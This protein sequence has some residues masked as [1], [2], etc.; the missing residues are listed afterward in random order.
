MTEG[1][2]NTLLE[3]FEQEVWSKVPHLEEKDGEA[4]VVNA[5]PLVDITE[6]F[7]ECAKKVYKINLDDANLKVFGKF[8]S[9]LLTGSIKVRPAAN[10]IHDA[11][12]TGKLTSGQTVIEATSGNFGIALGLLSK[13]ELNVIAL[14]S[15]KLQEGVFEELRN[16]NIR[17]MDLDMDICP[18]PGMEG[19]QDLLVAKASAANI[20]SQ[21][22]NLGFDTDIFDKAGS[23]I[24]S[25]LASQDIINL[26][27]FLA[28]IYGFFC[29]EQYDSQLNID[30]HRTIT[31][32]EID[33]QL[34]E[35]GDSLEGYNIFCTF[36]TGGT[37]G[38]LSRYISEKYGKKSV[39]VIYPPTNQ[40]VAGIRTKANADGLT[41]YEPEIYAAEQEMDWEQAKLLLK[42]FVEKGH[43]IGE[44]SALEL[45]AALQKA[46]SEG[47]GKFVVM[48]CDGI[49]KYKKNLASIGQEGPMQVSLQEANAGNYDKV[50]WIHA[51]YTP[52][53]QGIELIA[54]SL[55]ID[56]S[57]ISVP[58]A[59]TAQELLTT[60]Q[61]PE[62]LSKDLEGD[63]K[64][65]LVCMAGKTSLMA[66]KVLATKGV[67]TD[68]L[69]GGITELPEGKTKQLSDLIRQA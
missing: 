33:Q 42:F 50:I 58:D 38:G 48:I 61:I 65:L 52:L 13:L 8:D 21:L 53:E 45:Y 22:S 62:A 18:A 60:R 57:K 29:P 43:D 3:R 46:S 27:K 35:K 10:I 4:K 20:R 44:S 7:K 26:A 25:L 34:H 19:K 24:E 47:G 68:S 9:A 23:E 16:V 36:G 40:D 12:V 66:A 56:K 11:I 64:P 1:I 30:A 51:Q 2:D 17:T 39:Y 49:E 55:G 14:V 28:K 63:G 67:I 37:S 32:A 59:R 5:T 69:I 54:K 15:R 6:D 31:A 41:L